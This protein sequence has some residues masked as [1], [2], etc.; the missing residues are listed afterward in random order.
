MAYL[1]LDCDLRDNC[2]CCRILEDGV[3]S[4]KLRSTFILNVTKAPGYLFWSPSR[5]LCSKP[6][7][8]VF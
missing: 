5:I 3:I 8:K 7:R 2:A 6:F 1:L 4:S